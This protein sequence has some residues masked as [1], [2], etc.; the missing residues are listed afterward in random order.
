LELYDPD[1]SRGVIRR[2]A[3]GTRSA[4]SW[5]EF[6][7][8]GKDVFKGNGKGICVLSEVSS[9]PSLADM[10]KRFRKAPPKAGWFE[11]E[12]VTEIYDV[13]EE[14][15]S[16]RYAR[17]LDL[18]RAK[19]IVAVD[20]DLFG[21]S[22][23]LAIK[24]ARDFAAGRRLHGAD[25]EMNRLYVIES[26][27]TVT[28][29]CADHR[30]ALQPSAIRGFLRQLAQALG[31]A[32]PDMAKI[33]S[34]IDKAFV[35]RLKADLEANRGR[36]VIVP[37]KRLDPVLCMI[38]DVLNDV[39]E[40]HPAEAYLRVEKVWTCLSHKGL[41]KRPFER[42]DSACPRVCCTTD[43]ASVAIGMFARNTS[44]VK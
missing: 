35:Q 22:D 34:G 44:R 32:D 36:S 11:Y 28:G 14:W 15:Q 8:W 4:S 38:V 24:Y 10:R 31:L 43:L 23:P 3:D 7:R 2:S 12:P 1:R 9:S 30:R 6:A 29:A 25:G 18:T 39:L 16:D 20:A 5:E 17:V 13:Y 21:G 33:E 26:V 42:E 27:P 40:V 41:C 19:V 37:G